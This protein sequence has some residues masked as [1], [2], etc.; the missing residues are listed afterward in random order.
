MARDPDSLTIEKWATTGDTRTPEDRGLTR[1]TGWPADFSQPGGRRPTREIF[2]RMFLELTAMAVEL[3]SHGLLEWSNRVEYRHPAAV[4]ASDGMVYLSKLA[5]GP[6]QGGAIDPTG[7]QGS[8]GWRPVADPVPDA[9][10][11]VKGQVELATPVEAKAGTDTQR[12]V[13]PAGLAARTPDAST[14]V[15]GQVELA[16]PVEAKAGTDTQ[17]AVTPAGL[18]ART[19]DASTSVKGQVELATTHGEGAVAGRRWRATDTRSVR[20]RPAGLAARTPDASTSV[21]GQVELA[22][23][24]EAVAGTDTERAVT[25]AGLAARTPDA[26]ATRKG[27][28]ELATNSEVDTGTNTT[29]AVTPAGLESLRATTSRRGLIELAT[30]TETQTGTNTSRAVTP[31]GVASVLGSL[32]TIAADYD[33]AIRIN[34]GTNRRYTHENQC[35]LVEGSG[36]EIATNRDSTAGGSSSSKDARVGWAQDSVLA[37]GSLGFWV[38]GYDDVRMLVPWNNGSEIKLRVGIN[39]NRFLSIS[40]GHSAGFG[41]RFYWRTEGTNDFSGLS[42]IKFYAA[43]VRFG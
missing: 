22:T 33:F 1:S 30:P 37:S 28:V 6:N 5:S 12:A 43:E 8:T 17:R 23:T 39:P 18:A 26:T 31:A 41:T 2:N 24:T 10:T 14:S 32:V 11:S 15:K 27:L 40:F 13:T 25:S 42:T 21:K 38:A 29:H 16:T 36:T 19:P 3:N 7:S 35:A 4:L 9:S 34:T 20:S